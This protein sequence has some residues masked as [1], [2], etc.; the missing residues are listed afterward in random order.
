MSEEEY[1][2]PKLPGLDDLFFDI[3]PPVREFRNFGISLS[4]DFST[5]T[6]SYFSS[7]V[8]LNSFKIYLRSENDVRSWQ[9]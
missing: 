3:P 8:L 9:Y 2:P 4:L 7:V 5:S 1:S 6:T